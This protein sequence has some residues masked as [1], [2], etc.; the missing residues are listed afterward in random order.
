MPFVSLGCLWEMMFSHRPC[1]LN[2][3]TKNLR[4]MMMFFWVYNRTKHFSLYESVCA[5]RNFSFC[6][7]WFSF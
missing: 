4:E 5:Y 1:G 6:E 2:K 7:N 3:P